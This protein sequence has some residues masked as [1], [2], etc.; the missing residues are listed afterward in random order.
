MITTG[1]RMPR[2]SGCAASTTISER[3]VVV[4]KAAPHRSCARV[5]ESSYRLNLRALDLAIV[6]EARTATRDPAREGGLRGRRGKAR[7]PTSTL[8]PVLQ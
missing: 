7:D 1:S 4:L 2:S 6:H 3:C 8:P 5:D